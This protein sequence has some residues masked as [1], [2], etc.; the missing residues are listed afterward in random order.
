MAYVPS[1]VLLP[2]LLNFPIPGTFKSLVG[3]DL[4][5]NYLKVGTATYPGYSRGYTPQEDEVELFTF[6]FLGTLPFLGF[7]LFLPLARS[8]GPLP[9]SA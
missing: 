3:N 5:T 2:D 8:F 7:L 1:L 6:F 9:S 4:I